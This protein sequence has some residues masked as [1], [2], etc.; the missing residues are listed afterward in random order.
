M[1]V[2]AI[3]AKFRE[4][5]PTDEEFA[6]FR[7]ASGVDF[8]DALDHIAIHVARRF[9][10]GAMSYTDGDAIMNGVWSFALKHDEIPDT[11]YRI[12]EAFDSG[13]YFRESDPA[14]TDPVERYTR[15]ALV[16]ALE[17]ERAA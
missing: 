16:K 14:G 6:L 13:E 8:R 17:S 9:L 11:M 4:H 10:E 12:Y 2:E 5:W 1:N 15:P 3:S 7:R